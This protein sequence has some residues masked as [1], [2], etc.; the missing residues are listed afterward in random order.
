[1]RALVEDFTEGN[2]RYK[3]AHV[4]FTEGTVLFI[5]LCA[6]KYI[7]T[8]SDMMVPLLLDCKHGVTEL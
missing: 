6:L 3:C 1:M 4:F 7:L 8:S 2:H 5:Y